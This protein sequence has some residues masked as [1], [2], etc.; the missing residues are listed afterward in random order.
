MPT[1]MLDD[2]EL[3]AV[4]VIRQEIE[5]GYR[6]RRIAGLD[7]TLHEHLGRRSHRVVIGGLLL[8]DTAADDL[9]GLQK[10][11]ASGEEVTFTADIASALD[12]EKMVIESFAAEQV[13]GPAGQ[14]AYAILL[15]ES[16]KLPP[17]AEVSAF[18][19]L[20]DFGMGDLGF[21][22]GA[23]GDVLSGIA[24]QAAG[25][26][27][28]ADAAMNAIDQLQKLAALADLANLGA[29]GNPAQPVVDALGAVDRLAPL[30]QSITDSSATL[31]S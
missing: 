7:G 1:P 25:V 2:I 27:A 26:M 15:A 13:V 28:A 12:I 6:R 16:P 23:L 22:P 8:A 31:T 19:G 18:G 9:A 11:A 5:Q 14:T 4:Q 20:G 30:V 17:P 24:D 3:K 10:K 21:D 29:I